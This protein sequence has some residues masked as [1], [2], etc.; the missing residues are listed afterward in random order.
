MRGTILVCVFLLLPGSEGPSSEVEMEASYL[1]SWRTDTSWK[2]TVDSGGRVSEVKEEG[3][4]EPI[5]KVLPAKLK[6][7]QVDT[8]VAALGDDLH[9]LPPVLKSGLADVPKVSLLVRNGP[10]VLLVVVEAPW[11]RACTADMQKFAKAWNL[12]LRNFKQLK[13]G[14]EKCNL[15]S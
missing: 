6:K 15:C 5:R 14:G 9:G 13:C 7:A 1:R 11:D 12:L 10:N 8:L 3:Q 4:G 2:I